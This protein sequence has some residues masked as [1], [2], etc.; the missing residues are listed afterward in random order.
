MRMLRA[1]IH[2]LCLALCGT[3]FT[4]AT[5][6]AAGLDE[7]VAFDIPAQSLENALFALS[8]QSSYQIVFTSG[9]LPRRSVPPLNGKM[10]VKQALERLLEGTELGYKLVGERTITV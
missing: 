1:T 2:A 4:G 5:A 7:S 9:S 10:P 6:D 3:G 8:K